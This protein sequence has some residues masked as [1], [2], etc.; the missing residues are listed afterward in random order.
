MHV[1]LDVAGDANAYLLELQQ[2][3]LG[4]AS[5]SYASTLSLEYDPA[6]IA[7]GCVSLAIKFV[8]KDHTNHYKL[9]KMNKW[10][11][12]LAG[13]WTS[14]EDMD[15]AQAAMN[16]KKCQIEGAPQCFHGCSPQWFWELCAI[17]S[18]FMLTHFR[19]KHG[20]LELP[21]AEQRLDLTR[22][23]GCVPYF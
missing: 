9:I 5:D 11:K 22:T 3:A 2:T 7:A 8:T 12:D 20:M 23:N 1:I 6:V 13:Y 4:L 16:L 17:W 15:L 10:V 21:C 18:H 19:W 14:K